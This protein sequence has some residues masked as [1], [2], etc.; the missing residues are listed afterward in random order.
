MQVKKIMVIGCPGS[1]KSY[2]SCQL[3]R[4]T[5]LPLYH[6]DRLYWKP[7]WVATDSEE[8]KIIVKDVVEQDKWIIDGNYG[9]TLEMRFQ[10]ADIVYF[11]DLPTEVCLKSAKE[12]IGK[13]RSD[14]PEYLDEAYDPEF[15]TYIENFPQ[16][17][18]LYILELIRKYPHKLVITFTSREEVNEYL[19]KLKTQGF[20]PNE[21][22]E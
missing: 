19:Q 21:S 15:M 16:N 8:F 11:L 5:K 7:N 3:E 14:L 20:T 2:F 4:L 9:K 17:G 6:L 1:G 12:R 10:V 22:G 13:K 18:R